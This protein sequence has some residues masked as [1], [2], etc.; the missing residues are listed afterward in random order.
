MLIMI[1]FFL[2]FQGLGCNYPIDPG[3]ECKGKDTRTV[4]GEFS[5]VWIWIALTVFF[6]FGLI[7][8]IIRDIMPKI[9]R[10]DVAERYYTGESRN[11]ARFIIEEYLVTG[12]FVSKTEWRFTNTSRWCLILLIVYTDMLITG[13]LYEQDYDN[14]DNFKSRDFVYG[15]V[16]TMITFLFYL[17]AYFLLRIREKHEEFLWRKVFGF[18]FTALVFIVTTIFVFVFTYK[19]H[20]DHDQ[21]FTRLV[22]HWMSAFGYS[23]LLEVLISENIRLLTRTVII[24]SKKMLPEEPMQTNIELSSIERNKNPYEQESFD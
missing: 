3:S 12:W 6:I 20:D 4:L 23:M 17:V 16:S 1:I 10:T 15:F 2:V 7:V 11:I 9:P 19:V 5:M 18:V 21:D 8:S 24:W 13:I 22:D 14:P